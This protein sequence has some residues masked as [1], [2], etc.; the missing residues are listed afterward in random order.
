VWK[1]VLP[2]KTWRK[3]KLTQGWLWIYTSWSHSHRR[4]CSAV[5]HLTALSQ[6]TA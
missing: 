4:T 5:S 3:W 2:H 6:W 1:S